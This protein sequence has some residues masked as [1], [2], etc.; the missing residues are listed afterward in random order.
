MQN[1]FQA[2]CNEWAQ[3][4]DQAIFQGKKEPNLSLFVPTNKLRLHAICQLIVGI[5]RDILLDSE[6]YPNEYRPMHSRSSEVYF[7]VDALAMGAHK[8]FTTC[9]ECE[10]DMGDARFHRCSRCNVARNCCRVCHVRAWKSGHKSQCA[11]LQRSCNGFL[12]L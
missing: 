1:A 9:W 4:V 6:K 11:A 12:E 2:T 5:F 3:R 8:A 10:G 7:A